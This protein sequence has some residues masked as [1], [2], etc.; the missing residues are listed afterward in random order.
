MI[1]KNLLDKS[2]LLKCFNELM[3]PIKSSLSD[4]WAPDLRLAACKL[5]EK[6]LLEV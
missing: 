5:V 1:E 2:V 3:P 4:D 6:I